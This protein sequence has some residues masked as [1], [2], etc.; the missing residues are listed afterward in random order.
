MCIQSARTKQVCKVMTLC[1]KGGF[2]IPQLY[3]NIHGLKANQ[4]KRLEHIYRRRI[5][6]NLLITPELGRYLTELSQEIGRQ[7]G[8]IVNRKGSI[9]AAI[10]G[11]EKEIVIPV[12]ADYPLGRKRLRGLRCIHTHLKNEP[13][14]QD[15]LTDLAL[16]RLDIM[17]AIR[18]LEDG[19]P[20]D[21][22]ISHLL[23]LNPEGTPYKLLDKVPFHQLNLNLPDFLHQIDEEIAFSHKG[24]DIERGDRAVIVSASQKGRAEQEDTL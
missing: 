4:L 24:I 14:N 20:S 6:H 10:V 23:P 8:I 17:A 19:L 5:P 3:G 12:L 11:D 18:I 7:I 9:I 21:I 13:L 2:F 16:L 15:D 1:I 22:F